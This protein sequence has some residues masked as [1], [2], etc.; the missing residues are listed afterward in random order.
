MK[1]VQTFV[2]V[3]KHKISKQ[4][5]YQIMLSSYSAFKIYGNCKLYTNKKT[6]EA[7]KQFKFFFTEIDTDLLD[8][9]YF[10]PN[11]FAIPKL[12]VFRA[13]TEPF[14]HIDFDTFLL[15]ELPIEQ[16]NEFFYS[17]DDYS[18]LN[19]NN[20]DLKGTYK[21]MKYSD[22]K[23]VY[24]AYFESLFQLE[25]YFPS[26]LIN[27]LHVDISP[28]FCIFGSHNFELLNKVI[29]IQILIYERNRDIFNKDENMSQIFEQLLFF[30]ILSSLDKDFKYWQGDK[31]G[32]EGFFNRVKRLTKRYPFSLRSEGDFNI[33]E[34]HG[35]S[36]MIFPSEFD[37]I[38]DIGE[39]TNNLK[40][41]FLN[42]QA[43]Q[44]LLNADLGDFIH[45]GGLKGC[46]TMNRFIIDL[47]IMRN[48]SDSKLF[49]AISMIE[50]SS[51]IEFFEKLNLSDAYL[52]RKQNLK[53]L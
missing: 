21:S 46:Q 8:S 45:L 53:I 31:Y 34:S 38:I 20:E 50:K 40:I 36:L 25:Q 7:I 43:Y 48:T 30:P 10:E 26:S 12:H 1:I 6:W 42:K 11:S 44:K 18:F 2:L 24:K 22:L 9:L 17:Y 15:K 39:N 19:F 29:N 37:P 47:F 14:I 33:I 52:Y 41:S 35:N 28:N 49:S 51:D 13:Q 27:D 4:L 32:F 23:F 3:G 5:L 16:H